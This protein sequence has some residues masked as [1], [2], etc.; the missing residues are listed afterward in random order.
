MQPQ[1]LPVQSPCWNSTGQVGK[2]VGSAK[3]LGRKTDREAVLEQ[4]A[5]AVG[6]VG[7]AR[8]QECPRKWQAR[9]W[10]LHRAISG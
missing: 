8:K 6:P 1:R 3:E 2:R 10:D 7:K 9:V 4:L 5:S